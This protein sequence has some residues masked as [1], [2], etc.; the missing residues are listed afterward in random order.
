ML[1]KRLIG[2]NGGA[3][4]VAEI[5][6]NHNGSEDTATEMIGLAAQYGADAVKFQKR[7]PAICIPKEQQGE[8]RQTPWGRMTYLDY[9]ERLEFT[10]GE[11]SRVALAAGL[12]RIECFASVWDVPSVAFMEKFKPSVYKIPSPCLTDH[13]LLDAVTETGRPVIL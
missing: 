11:Y 2:P 9:R 4:I 7:T 1:G 8:M 5:G 3:Y 10:E 12:W 13:E 6:A